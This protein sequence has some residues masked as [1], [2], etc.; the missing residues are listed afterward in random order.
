MI[1]FA[2]LSLSLAFLVGCSGSDP[3]SD[4]VIVRAHMNTTGYRGKA[5]RVSLSGT[6]TIDPQ[7]GGD[8]APEVEALEP[9]PADCL[10]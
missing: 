6:F 10:Y 3:E 9:Q 8:F 5:I 4:E 7:I 2:A 1:R